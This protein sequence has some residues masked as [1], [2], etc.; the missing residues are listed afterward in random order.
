MIWAFGHIT[1]RLEYLHFF[2][3]C[4]Y[5]LLT[6]FLCVSCP[7]LIPSV[8]VTTSPGIW[9]SGWAEVDRCPWDGKANSCL[10]VCSRQRG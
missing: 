2:L 9:V 8:Q 4:V 10:M 1:I 6:L 5:G 7:F 3:S